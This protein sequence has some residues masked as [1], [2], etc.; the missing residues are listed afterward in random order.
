M[1]LV[2]ALKASRE[3][4]T[5]IG[6]ACLRGH[7]DVV[8]M[9]L[10]NGANKDKADGDS[11]TPLGLASQGGHKQIVRLLLEARADKDKAARD[12]A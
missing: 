10:E 12:G 7:Q 5:P 2:V 1:Y 8:R 4:M 3:G 9:L 11:A 6:M